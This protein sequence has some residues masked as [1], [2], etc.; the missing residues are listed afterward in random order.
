MSLTVPQDLLSQAQRG[1]VSDHEFVECIRES[2]PYAWSVVNELAGKLSADGGPFA[3]NRT[4]PP[5]DDSFGQ[6][7]RLAAS[8]AMRSAVERHFGVRVA[9]QN[10]CRLALFEPSAR[11]AYD[12][13]VTPRAQLLNQRPEFVNC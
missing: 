5:D 3:D 13:F 10:C 8:D 9:F 1:P 4:Q 7:L 12:E 6:L 11:A 2:L